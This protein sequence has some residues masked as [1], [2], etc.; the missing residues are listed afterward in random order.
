TDRGTRFG[1]EQGSVPERPDEADDD[2]GNDWLTLVVEQR[3]GESTPAE[4]LGKRAEDN[5]NDE[6]DR[7]PRQQPVVDLA[8]AAAKRDIDRGSGGV[9]NRSDQERREKPQTANSES[10]RSLE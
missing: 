3:Q 9:E 1:P 10:E 6:H 2:T 7:D 4:F 5:G 8:H